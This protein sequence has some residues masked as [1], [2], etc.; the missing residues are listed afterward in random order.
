MSRSCPPDIEVPRQ[1]YFR[2]RDTLRRFAALPALIAAGFVAFS[3]VLSPPVARATSIL[4]VFRFATAEEVATLNPEL[5]QQLVVNWLSEMTAAYLF[6]LDAH[7]A[8]MPEL[9][10]V[11]PTEQNGGISKDG[12]RITLHLRKNVKWSDGTPFDADDVAFSIDAMKN[13]ANNV[14]DRNGLDM[15]T[16]ID[17]PDKFTVVVHLKAPIGAIVYGLF[18]TAGS[19]SVLPKHI[20]GSLP[21][22][23]EAPFNSLPVGI[24]PFRYK[25]WKRGEQIELEANPYYWRGRPA[26]SEVVMKLIPDRNTV[27]LQLQTGEID[28]W[29]PFGGSFLSR[30]Q[31]IPN[32]TLLRHPSYVTNEMLFNAQDPVVKDVDVRRALR[33]AINRPELRDKVQH[34]V[35]IL[36]NV[37]LPQVDPLVPKD[38]AF[39][40]FDLAKA[41][42][43]LDAAGWKRGSDGVREK[44]GT[45]L[46]I[47]V[48][49]SVGTPDADTQI[50]LIRSTF[51]D[52]GA[53]LNV[54]RYQSS[55]LFGPYADGG[56][57][58]TGKFGALFLGNDIEPPFDMENAFGCKSIPPGGQNDTR[59]CNAALQATITTYQRT[60]DFETRKRLLSKILHQV[61]DAAIIIPTVGREDLFGFSNAVKNFAP[62]NATPFDNMM[63]VDVIP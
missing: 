24:G 32:V 45:R 18:S 49:S 52:V 19:A 26:L 15:V 39:T 62:N 53:E 30:V 55:I 29:Y 7:N 34:G 43:I 1:T 40:P 37:I 47:N 12:L 59:Y 36:Q 20:L 4:H 61:D 38:I 6:R 9:A 50:E 28:M 57:L 56:I 25:A 58:A 10:T 17:E 33:Y 46:T 5:N 42:A 21:N 35:G 3:G 23:N 13:P 11:V 8:L 54:N 41:N 22:I 44:N 27:L 2:E 16:K 63:R 60:Y 14:P 31:A 48:A 51:K